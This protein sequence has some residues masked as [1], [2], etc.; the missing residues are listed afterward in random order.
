MDTELLERIADALERIAE[1]VECREHR[2]LAIARAKLRKGLAGWQPGEICPESGMH[3]AAGKAEIAA[4]A[5]ALRRAQ[6]GM[7]D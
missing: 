1:V 5:D 2:E 7:E 4:A 3:T 6:A